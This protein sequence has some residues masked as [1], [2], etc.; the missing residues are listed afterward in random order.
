MAAVIER[1]TGQPRFVPG[2]ID[3]LRLHRFTLDE[4]R[5]LAES[6]A[7]PHDARVELLDGW[8]VDMTPIGPEH[9]YAVEGFRA[10]LARMLPDGWHIR[11]QQPIVIGESE[12]QPDI[13]IVRGH[14]ADYLR[15]H[16]GA[17][18]IG[19]VLE[20]ADR[21][22]S[23]DR[24]IKAALYAAAGISEYWIV[25]LIKRQVEVFRDPGKAKGKPAA[26]RYSRAFGRRAKLPFMLEGREL[27]RIEFAALLP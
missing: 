22:L 15:R 18:D 1:R 16:P 10:A 14:Y 13:T 25:N 21:S 12:P 5:G 19:W 23:T 7:V 9:S 24:R 11:S 27:G 20:V 26:Y 2:P 4:Y 8:I 3:A 6:G 17:G